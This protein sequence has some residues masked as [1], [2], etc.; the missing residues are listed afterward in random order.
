MQQWFSQG[1]RKDTDLDKYAQKEQKNDTSKGPLEAELVK[2]LKHLKLNNIYNWKPKSPG[3]NY[4]SII[5]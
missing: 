1:K 5:Y 2:V 4:E 3:R